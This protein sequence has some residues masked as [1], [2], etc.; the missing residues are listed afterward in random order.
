MR[1]CAYTLPVSAGRHSAIIHLQAELF[2]LDSRHDPVSIMQPPTPAEET[3]AKV[4]DNIASDTSIKK[5]RLPV[6]KKK[7]A[8]PIEPDAAKVDPVVIAT[9]SA[10]LSETRS[11]GPY[12]GKCRY[13]S[14]KCENERAIKRNGKPHN[15][16]E[17]HR[18]KQNQ[19]QR[20]FDAKTFSRKRRRDSVSDEDTKID[21][22]SHRNEEPSA[23]HHRPMT[24]QEAEAR[25]PSHVT[26]SSAL[27]SIRGHFYS[28]TPM[29]APLTRLPPIQSPRGPILPPPPAVLYSTSGSMVHSRFRAVAAPMSHSKQQSPHISHR[30]YLQQQVSQPPT[31]YSHSELVAASILVQPQYS[32]PCAAAST[33]VN[34][35]VQSPISGESRG[36]AVP[37]QR[38]LPSR[39]VPSSAS[40]SPS[41]YYRVS[42]I[43]PSPSQRFASVVVT[44]V[45]SV[46]VSPAGNMLPPLVAFG[47]RR[48]QTSP[49]S[50]SKP[51]NTGK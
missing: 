4:S 30:P 44:P 11:P 47:L 22:Q 34:Y 25:T 3:K 50:I 45:S 36:Q 33:P 12:R 31:G 43:G 5:R 41:P 26:P 14:R 2:A 35:R 42:G 46:S 39:V 38:V 28:T 24:N 7:A 20:K 9:S 49:K 51:L 10:Q 29:S 27:S 23:K 6:K 32:P 18:S 13:Q 8:K 40:L 19:H 1:S 17:E 48:S 16:C 15:L 37:T 21:K